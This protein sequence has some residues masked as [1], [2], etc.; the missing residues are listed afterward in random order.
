MPNPR[1]EVT[2]AALDGLLYAG[3]GLQAGGGATDEVDVYNPTADKWSR[4]VPFPE[5]LHHTSLVASGGRLYLIGG[6]RADGSASAKVWS[7]TAGEKTWR[8]EP[9]LR[10]AR[11]AFGAAVDSGGRIHVF[12][13]ASRFE[14]LGRLVATNEV[15]DPRQGFWRALGDMPGP[16][17]HLTAAAVGNTIVVIGGRDLSYTKNMRRVDIFNARTNAWRSGPELRKARGGIAAAAV[18][19]LVCVFGG[20]DPS[21]TFPQVECLDVRHGEWRKAPDLP[22]SRHGLGAAQIED[23]VYVVG[24]GPR[25]GISVSGA[26]E[27]LRVG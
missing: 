4:S 6:Y 13:G 18:G 27:V 2:A 17:D 8:A 14:P 12:G 1:T 19:S 23:R 25:P 9:P 21:G 10:T 24:G 5:P 22:T 3:G 15:M 7:R 26:N 11:G 20:E 16:R